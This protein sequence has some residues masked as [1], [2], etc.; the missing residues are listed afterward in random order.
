[1]TAQIFD[2]AVIGGGPAG[3]KTA[4]MIAE[5]GHRVLLLEKRNRIGHPVRCAEAVGPYE[6]VRRFI[7][8]DD[9]IVSST[10]NGIVVVSPDGTRFEAS[11]PEIGYVVD[12]ELFDLRLAETASQAGARVRTGHQAVELLK[13]GGSV[14]GLIV[15][16]LETGDHYEV[17]AHV[18]VGADGVEGLSTRWAGLAGPLRPDEVMSCAQELMSGI[19]LSDSHIEFHLGRKF[20]PGGYA[21]VFP[22]GVDRANVGVGI[23]PRESDGR[24]ALE[25]LN[26]FIEHR[27]PAGERNRLVIGASSVASGLPKLATDGY[28]AVGEAARQNNPFSGGG[29]INALEGAEMASGVILKA[30]DRGEYSSRLLNEYS[31]KW[32][33]TVGRSNRAYYHAARIFYSLDEGEMNRAMSRLGRTPGLIDETGVRPAKIIRI[34]ASLYPSLALKLVK[35][36]VRDKKT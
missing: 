21:W 34:L 9:S 13:R 24:S 35:S 23:N 3:S 15:K 32:N 31:K 26:R 11:T 16:D 17:D 19:D 14:A 1:M 5:K 33:R 8:L 20:A 4:A 28:L 7:S 22:K 36:L 18:V 25:Y 30:L 29:I 27:C 12:R 10:V 2:A 6:D